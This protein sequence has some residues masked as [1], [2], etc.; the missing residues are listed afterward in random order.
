MEDTESIQKDSE[1][2]LQEITVEYQRKYEELYDKYKVAVFNL[3][4]DQKKFEEALMQTEAEYDI[5]LKNTKDKYEK[6]LQQHKQFAEKTR[7][8][9]GKLKKE[10]EKHKE[11]DQNLNNLI[12]ETRN[13][14]EQLS[15]EIRAHNEK[16]K[17]MDEQLRI[18]EKLINEKEA[19]IK[20]LRTKNQHLQNFKS[21]YDHRV[22]TLK[23]ESV[24][25]NDY[26]ENLDHHISSLYK[27]L[28]SEAEANKK[29]I[30]YSEQL[31]EVIKGLKGDLVDRDGLLRKTK[32]QLECFEY[33]ALQVVANRGEDTGQSH[34]H[35]SG[36]IVK[37]QLEELLTE[38]EI[39]LT[40]VEGVLA[41]AN[42]VFVTSMIENREAQN[43]EKL[44]TLEMNAIKDE[45]IRLRDFLSKKL[46][47]TTIVN[48]RMERE[49]DFVYKKIQNDGKLLIKK[50]NELR[51]DKMDIKYK[52]GTY[53][54]QAKELTREVSLSFAKLA[55]HQQ[56]TSSPNIQLPLANNAS[57][58][59]QPQK[60]KGSVPVGPASQSFPTIKPQPNEISTSHQNIKRSG[61]EG[62]QMADAK[63]EKTDKFANEMSQKDM[64]NSMLREADKYYGKNKT[65]FS[66]GNNSQDLET[67]HEKLKS[68]LL[69]KNGPKPT[70]FEDEE[71]KMMNVLATPAEIQKK[72]LQKK[73]AESKSGKLKPL[74]K[75]TKPTV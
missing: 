23:D 74:A 36:N 75:K 44:S 4:I 37:N 50:C 7:T 28:L 70:L 67:F 53:Q 24:P 5:D 49:R 2:V 54:K 58:A 71:S 51:T 72:K 33:K 39:F 69:L 32:R 43:L 73:I 25:L 31:D 60:N 17:E 12:A 52:L 18:R 21:V 15:L 20:D 55:E 61:F 68:L 45:L 57:G 34:G 13:Q 66:G 16:M 35:S 27:E 26:F 48:G 6:E 3:K 22:T 29:L 10:N 38:S 9:N 40:N 63:K 41:R 47:T 59:N 19:N 42:N 56:M 30:N 11:R 62:M 65:G 1:S 46:Q 14:N 64:L 8:Q